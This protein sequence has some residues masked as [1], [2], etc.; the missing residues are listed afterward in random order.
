VGPHDSYRA[1]TATSPRV[2]DVATSFAAGSNRQERVSGGGGD[3]EGGVE[4]GWVPHDCL[5]STKQQPVK[6]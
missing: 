6:S 3:G 4:A 5:Q 1:Q 2:S